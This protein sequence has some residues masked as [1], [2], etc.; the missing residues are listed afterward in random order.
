LSA[1]GLR[2]EYD[3]LR[4]ELTGHAKQ[5]AG[6]WLLQGGRGSAVI[7]QRMEFQELTRERFVKVIEDATS[8]RVTG[9]MS[10]NQQDPDMMCETF[11]LA[12][13]D[14]VDGHEE[15]DASGGSGLPA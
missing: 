8:R 5:P 12:P 10:G 9:F 11:I 2:R 13:S 6:S 14:L 3:L 1:G 7:Q 4:R 15:A